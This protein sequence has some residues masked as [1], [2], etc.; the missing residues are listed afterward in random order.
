MCRCGWWPE[1]RF[2]K[3]RKLSKKRKTDE[4]ASCWSTRTKLWRSSGGCIPLMMGISWIYMILFLEKGSNKKRWSWS[5]EL[6]SLYWSTRGARSHLTKL[7][8]RWPLLTKDTRRGDRGTRRILWRQGWRRLRMR[9]ILNYQWTTHLKETSSCT[10]NLMA[11]RSQAGAPGSSPQVT[12]RRS[13][14]SRR[15]RLSRI[16]EHW[17]KTNKSSSLRT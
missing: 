9:S 8:R 6:L 1:T 3:S 4:T 17:A 2:R 11:R 13:R 5:K 7:S 14:T 12:R 10:E 15:C 16:T